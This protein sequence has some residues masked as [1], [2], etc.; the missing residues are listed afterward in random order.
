M[1]KIVALFSTLF[2]L[3]SCN[4]E[5]DTQQF[6]LDYDQLIYLDAENLAEQGILEA[7]NELKPKLS[8]LFSSLSEI[9]EHIESDTG[10]YSVKSMGKKY[11]IYGPKLN[12]GEGQSWGRATV[13]FFEIINLQLKGSGVKFYAINGGN[14][15]GGMFLT[16]GEY[17]AAIESIET[18]TD[19]PY[20]PKLEHPWYGQPN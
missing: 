16:D 14:D 3:S 10:A 1:K 2:G 7:Y 19:W 18:K 5:I 12:E 9:E 15:L 6:H 13:S 8:T 20:I 11:D 17:K 4:S